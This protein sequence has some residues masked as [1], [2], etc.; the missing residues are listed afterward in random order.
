MVRGT[1]KWFSLEKGYGFITPSDGSAAVFV[2]YSAIV[3]DETDDFKTLE[4]GQRVEFEIAD[5]GEGPHAENVRS[6]E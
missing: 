6:L 2:H 5:R 1:V 3:T 4:E